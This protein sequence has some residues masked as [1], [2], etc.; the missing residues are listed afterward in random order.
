MSAGQGRAPL[1][2]ARTGIHGMKAGAWRIARCRVEGVSVYVL[3]HDDGRR[4]QC[5]SA[6][7]ARKVADENECECEGAV[8]D[9]ND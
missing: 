9:G 8:R 7:A 2:W 6:E 3:T 4:W 1:A 5:D